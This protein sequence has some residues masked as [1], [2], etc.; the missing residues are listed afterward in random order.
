VI[1]PKEEISKYHKKL[2]DVGIQ[3]SDDF[4]IVPTSRKELEKT[5]VFNHSCNPN[6][7]F[8]NSITFV[9]MKDI[10]RGEE[11]TFDY[12]FS[13][14]LTQAFRCNC[15]CANCRKVIKST[16]WKRREL[17][18]KYGKYFSP[19]LKAKMGRLNITN[20]YIKGAEWK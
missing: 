8:S 13:E 16:D 19:Y 14:S 7:G 6:C 17:Q 9:A 10:K 12:A 11:L 5:G 15:G 2:G 4:F 20:P 1:V 3:I 18:K